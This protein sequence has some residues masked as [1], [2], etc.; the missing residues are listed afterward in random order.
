MILL[1]MSLVTPTCRVMIHASKM[2]YPDWPTSLA[3][4]VI[5]RLKKKYKPNDEI[6]TVELNTRLSRMK[7]NTILHPDNLFDKLAAIHIAYG[8][9]LGEGRQ[10]AEVMAKAPKLYTTTLASETRLCEA[11]KI[12]LT[13]DRLQSAMTRFWRIEHGDSDNESGSDTE[14]EGEIVATVLDREKRKCF[15]CGKSG[16]ISKKY[17]S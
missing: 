7:I 11:M 8:F 5:E 6:S 15:K 16:H 14:E 12:P 1:V 3:W 17:R 13:L 4:D 9:K 2:K 10:M